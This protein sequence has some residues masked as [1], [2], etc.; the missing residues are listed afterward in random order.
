MEVKMEV[1]MKVLWL[2]LSMELFVV[3]E[4]EEDEKLSVEKGK[5]EKEWLLE[6]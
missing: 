5:E 1:K 4:K 3:K 6:E 2:E